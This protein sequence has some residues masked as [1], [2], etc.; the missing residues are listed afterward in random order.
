LQE[1]IVAK[2]CAPAAAA[3]IRP[4]QD[5]A[6]TT[7]RP[8]VFGASP[9]SLSMVSLGRNIRAAAVIPGCDVTIPRSD[10]LSESRA[11][12]IVSPAAWANQHRQN[13]GHQLPECDCLKASFIKT[14]T[15]NRRAMITAA[16]GGARQRIENRAIPRRTAPMTN[17]EIQN[18]LRNVR[19]N[20]S[21][22]CFG[23][24]LLRIL[25]RTLSTLTP[26]CL[27]QPSRGARPRPSVRDDERPLQCSNCHARKTV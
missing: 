27:P 24:E 17:T 5:A 6:I 15:T 25:A 16:H 9:F 18:T 3:I 19:I 10:R 13:Q 26:T 23:G 12:R 11:F 2:F 22:A 21:P 8:R 1:W 14:I 20:P 4:S 7:A